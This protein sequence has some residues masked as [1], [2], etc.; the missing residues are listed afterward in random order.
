MPDAF[1]LPTD[2]PDRFVATAHTQGPWSA[3]LQHAG[4]P[5]A[6]LARAVEQVDTSVD[7]PAQ[8]TRLTVEI[9][10][11]V[12]VAE[13]TVRAALA[14]PGRSV[15]LVEAE[16]SAAGRPVLRARVWRIR[17]TPVGL[18]A[19]VIAAPVPPPPRPATPSEFTEPRWQTGYLRAIEWRFV[20]GHFERPGPAAVWARQRV[21]LV[22]GEE[23]SP[24][25]RTALLADSGN[26]LSRLLDMADW[27]FIN[28]ELTVHL[29]RQPAGDWI[30]VRAATTLDQQGSGLA[31]TVLSDATG[32]VGRGA[33]ALMVGR[34]DG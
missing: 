11:A 30:F 6:L 2:D 1:Y 13:V 34:R 28:T 29:H 22:A 9:L 5:S 33:Q 31:E 16:L 10:G 23:P 3:D 32:R 19:E 24:L 7:G 18:P 27:W 25:Q 15:E 14:R 4:P 26:G 8:V 17:R 20:E 21:P 12:P